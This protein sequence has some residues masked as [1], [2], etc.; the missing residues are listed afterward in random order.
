MQRHVDAWRQA[1]SDNVI[2]MYN[3]KKN[4]AISWQLRG[5]FQSNKRQRPSSFHEQQVSAAE[6]P[7]D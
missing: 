6:K 5:K 1:I 4:Q 2:E 3:V 7:S